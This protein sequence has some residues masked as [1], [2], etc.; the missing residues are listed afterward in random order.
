MEG[1]HFTTGAVDRVTV[2]TV[3]DGLFDM[4]P[5]TDS[6]GP[7]AQEVV[8]EFRSA[9]G[10]AGACVVDLRRAGEVNKQTLSVSFQFARS[11]KA[12]G[13]RRALCSAELRPI[14][15]M[16]KGG[17][18][19]PCFDEL[20]AAIKSVSAATGSVESDSAT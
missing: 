2:V 15:K 1:K 14:W 3:R 6:S 17:M 13:A 20:E 7:L 19:A 10:E 8:A 9:I 18:V 4:L 16:C 5:E 12:I 11:L